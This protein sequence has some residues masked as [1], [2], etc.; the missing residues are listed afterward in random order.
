MFLFCLHFKCCSEATKRIYIYCVALESAS[1]PILPCL[2]FGGVHL[3]YMWMRI[4]HHGKKHKSIELQFRLKF[5]CHAQWRAMRRQVVVLKHK[6]T[7]HTASI[8]KR[9]KYPGRNG[10]GEEVCAPKRKKITQSR[11][12]NIYD[13][14]TWKSCSDTF[15]PWCGLQYAQTA[16][17]KTH[18]AN[19]AQI[20]YRPSAMRRKTDK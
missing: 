1:G 8:G 11:W 5:H 14:E 20:R 13:A 6:H 7:H 12:T 10:D 2:I 9:N 3:L 16:E 19:W 18:R 4:E 17:S 15:N